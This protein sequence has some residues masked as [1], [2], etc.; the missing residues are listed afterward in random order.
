MEQISMAS[1]IY[2]AIGIVAFF[3]LVFMLK[4]IR[5]IR[6]NQVGIPTKKMF[7]KKMPAG[8]VFARRNEVGVQARKLMPGL[9]WFFPVI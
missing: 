3:F 1:I 7:G 5:L 4:G 6:D 8:Q 2:Y 9:Y